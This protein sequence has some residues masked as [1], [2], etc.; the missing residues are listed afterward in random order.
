MGWLYG[1]TEKDMVN[2]FCRARAEIGKGSNYTVISKEPNN[3]GQEGWKLYVVYTVIPLLL[4]RHGIV[5]HG[6]YDQT[7]QYWSD[8]GCSRCGESKFGP[9]L[10]RHSPILAI[11][12]AT[13]VLLYYRQSIADRLHKLR[14]NG[15]EAD[16]DSKQKLRTKQ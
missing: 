7:L 1:H 2:I 10:H 13:A 15:K 14:G 3:H 12:C 6:S 4:E 9:R 16:K 11:A 5:P 8:T